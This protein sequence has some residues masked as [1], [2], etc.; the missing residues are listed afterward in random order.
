MFEVEQFITST[1]LLKMKVAE[2]KSQSKD[3]LK[4]SCSLTSSMNAPLCAVKLFT[5][6]LCDFATQACRSFSWG[7][8]GNADALVLLQSW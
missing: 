6:T 8:A 5:E 2:I 7:L 3:H 4:T 1:L